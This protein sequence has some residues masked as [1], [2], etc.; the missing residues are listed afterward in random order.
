MLGKGRGDR[1]TCALRSTVMAELIVVAQVGSF[2]ISITSS[3]DRSI[4]CLL[5]EGDDTGA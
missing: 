2:D 3:S 4:P 1:R 5:E